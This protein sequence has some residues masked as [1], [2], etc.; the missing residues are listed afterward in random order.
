MVPRPALSAFTWK[1]SGNASSRPHP[2]PTQSGILAWALAI[3]ILTIPPGNADTGGMVPVDT[4][5]HAGP[6]G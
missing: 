1:R 5:V 2:R 4:P 6:T 3:C